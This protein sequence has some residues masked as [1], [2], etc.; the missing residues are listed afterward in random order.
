MNQSRKLILV[1]LDGFGEG[2]D[3]EGNAVTH[4]DTK[5][6]DYLRANYPHALLKSDG[7]AVG[8]PE[9]VQGGSEVGHV[10]IGAGRVVLQALEEINRSIASGDF[11][12]KETLI[13]ACRRVINTPKS[14][15]H[16]IGMISDQGVHATIEHLFALLKLA[17]DQ[18][19]GK[20]YIHA[21]TDGRDVPER[22]AKKYIQQLQKKIEELEMGKGS[23]SRAIIASIIGRYYALDRDS[24][25]DR[26]ARA[27]DVMVSGEGVRES[28]PIEAIE[29][30]YG[31][32]IETDYYIDP[33]LLDEDGIIGDYDSVIF[34]NFRTDRPRQLTC[35]FT[36]EK[37]IGFT[38]KKVVHPL[39]I[40]MG[41]FSEKAPVAFP[42]PKIKNNLGAVLSQHG[43]KQ[44]RMA[45]T[46]KYAHVTYFFNSQV[47]EP[48]IGEDRILIDS[49]KVSSYAKAPE[50]SAPEI[51]ERLMKEMGNGNYRVI[52]VNFAN[53]DL[54]GHSGDFAASVKAVEIIDGVLKKITEK[55]R[56]E[57]YEVLITGDHGNIEYMIYDEGKERGQPC[58]SHTRNPVP[59]ILVSED[60]KNATLRSG[61]LGDIAPT[62]L[63]ILDIEKPPEMTGG[64]LIETHQ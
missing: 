2:K 53:C 38:P 34:W 7:N 43:M 41:E 27:Y 23:S 18:G 14:A 40:C 4:A 32:G 51:T 30:A 47:H 16:L 61:E 31:R 59:L 37:K 9:G 63:A 48:F 46:E 45:E 56:S 17:K 21:I 57:K 13:N 36:G 39:F 6:L 19:V 26:T 25:W 15:L 58:P 5:T 64:N 62:M 28:D 55:A 8:L 22:S 3:Y 10:T 12:K 11:F 44:L 35:A 60:F 42:T 24:N 54:V 29:N 50:M 49:K 1:I 33:I 20:I 52:I